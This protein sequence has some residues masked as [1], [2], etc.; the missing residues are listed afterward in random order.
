MNESQAKAAVEGGTNQGELVDLNITRFHPALRNINEYLRD[1]EILPEFRRP[2]RARRGRPSSASKQLQAS[3]Q[4]DQRLFWCEVETD[5]AAEYWM[6]VAGVEAVISKDEFNKFVLSIRCK[7][8]AAYIAACEDFA[9]N[10]RVG[11]NE[12]RRSKAA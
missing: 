1:H 5:L 6:A 2:E 3:A 9:R 11:R 8:G 10:L 12:P 7:S 4:G